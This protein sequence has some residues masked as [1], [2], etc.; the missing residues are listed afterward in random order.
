[1]Q[2]EV[3]TRVFLVP[4]EEF[5]CSWCSSDSRAAEGDITLNYDSY[6]ASGQVLGVRSMHTSHASKP[7]FI[8]NSPASQTSYPFA[9]QKTSLLVKIVANLTCFVPD[10]CKGKKKKKIANLALHIYVC[11]CHLLCLIIFIVFIHRGEKSLP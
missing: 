9:H 1:M 7:V 3:L 4:H 2:T 11:I 5:L 8:T 10:L 6:S